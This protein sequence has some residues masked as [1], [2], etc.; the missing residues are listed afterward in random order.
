[1]CAQ[2]FGLLLI[3][4]LNAC[5]SIDVGSLKQWFKIIEPLIF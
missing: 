2:I 3:G 5:T 1:M 4:F